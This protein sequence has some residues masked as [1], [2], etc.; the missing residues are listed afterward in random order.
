MAENRQSDPR[1]LRALK[2]CDAYGQFIA[3]RHR[4][5]ATGHIPD[6]DQQSFVAAVGR[7]REGALED[8]V[9][10]IQRIRTGALDPQV[11]RKLPRFDLDRHPA[12]QSHPNVPPVSNP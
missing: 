3:L 11:I 10:C 8:G 4:R 1:T 6:V 12:G 5:L 7:E 2:L 9:S